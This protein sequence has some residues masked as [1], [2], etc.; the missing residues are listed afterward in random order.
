MPVV[1]TVDASAGP[2]A[3]LAREE[4]DSSRQRQLWLLLAIVGVVVVGTGLT[5][6]IILA[7]GVSERG[8]DDDDTASGQMEP[9]QDNLVIQQPSGALDFLAAD[10]VIHGHSARPGTVAGRTAITR[11]ISSSDW[12]SWDFRVEQPAVFRVELIYAA[13]PGAGGKFSVAIDGKKTG[14]MRKEASVRGTAGADEFAAHEIGFLTVRRSG[15]HRLA[16][17]VVSKRAGQLMILRAIHLTPRDVGYI[18]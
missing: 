2:S 16:M 10:A 18:R 6:L 4:S 17:R 3:G 9:M 12:L 8:G 14:D 1:D 13:P 7:G 11:W 5:V 15:R